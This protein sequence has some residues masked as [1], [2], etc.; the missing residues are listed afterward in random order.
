MSITNTV[1]KI[2][3][4][5]IENNWLIYRLVKFCKIIKWHRKDNNHADIE[6]ICMDVYP[7]LRDSIDLFW[8]KHKCSEVGCYNRLVVCDGN[9]KLYRYICAKKIEKVK[10]NSGTGEVNKTIRC[11][12]NPTRGNQ[13]KKYSKFCNQH[14]ENTK[15][16]V[17]SMPERMDLR[18]ITRLYASHLSDVLISNEGCKTISN[19]NK[20]EDRTAGLFYYFRGCGV[21][22]SH[23]E[24]YTAESL[25]LVFTSLIDLFGSNPLPEDITGI[26]YDIIISSSD[27]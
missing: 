26:I 24:M 21:R 22:I 13:N 16:P 23:V 9:E 6:S 5:I 2:S 11:I 1:N 17:N 20:F 15:I 18:P 12:N 14:Q 8:L 10:G 19:L 25:S 7:T 3:A 27:T 4:E